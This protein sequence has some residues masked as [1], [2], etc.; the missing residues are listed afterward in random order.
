MI[1]T[2][3]ITARWKEE[4]KNVAPRPERGSSL[5][6]GAIITSHSETHGEGLRAGESARDPAH[7]LTRLLKLGPVAPFV[8]LF[9]VIL[10]QQK[11]Q[12]YLERNPV[13][14]GVLQGRIQQAQLVDERQVGSE[15]RAS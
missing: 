13:A 4:G 1:R 14:R 8:I 3:Y 15:T 9:G 12:D 6:L 5:H 2:E 10:C 11:V 7:P